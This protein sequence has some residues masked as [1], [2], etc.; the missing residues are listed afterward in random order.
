M[1]VLTTLEASLHGYAL[2]LRHRLSQQTCS[3]ALVSRIWQMQT[4]VRLLISYW[5]ME[6]QLDH[7][8]YAS[9]RALHCYLE[10]H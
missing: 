5:M 4:V 10:C 8:C 3:F 2:A 1:E 7:W 9:S 6:D